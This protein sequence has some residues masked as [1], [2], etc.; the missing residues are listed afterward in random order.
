MSLTVLLIAA[1][2]AI[3]VAIGR[4]LGGKVGSFAA[5]IIMSII[6][7]TTG[8]PQYT[9]FDLIAIWIAFFLL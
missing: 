9:G 7:V 3:P 1:A 5:A 4:V 8:S 6:A 2:H